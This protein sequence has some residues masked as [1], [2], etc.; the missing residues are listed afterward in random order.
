M[1][2]EK[3][4]V[5]YDISLHNTA[6]PSVSDLCSYQSLCCKVIAQTKFVVQIW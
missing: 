6:V 1:A 4:I 2:E 3:V 5:E